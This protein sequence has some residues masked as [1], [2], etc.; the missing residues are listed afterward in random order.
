MGTKAP[1][2]VIRSYV[3]HQGHEIVVTDG[4]YNLVLQVGGRR[5]PTLK[6]AEH[7]LKTLGGRATILRIHRAHPDLLEA[8]EYWWKEQARIHKT[9]PGRK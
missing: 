7:A 9:V 4:K 2:V 5:Y 3:H 8:G 6:E 1:R